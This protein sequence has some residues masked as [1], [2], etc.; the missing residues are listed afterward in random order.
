MGLMRKE[1]VD[2][3]GLEARALLPVSASHLYHD[4][5]N[6]RARSKWKNPADGLRAGAML[7]RLEG[8][9]RADVRRVE[10]D[11]DTG[12]FEEEVSW[13]DSYEAEQHVHHYGKSSAPVCWSLVGYSSGFVSACL[14]G[15]STFAK[16]PEAPGR[17]NH[18]HRA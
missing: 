12:R 15:R 18:R 6:L 7:H 8:I 9:V 14:A 5:V 3:L 16:S 17:D 10:Y 2:T 4:A 11:E 1:L 13:H